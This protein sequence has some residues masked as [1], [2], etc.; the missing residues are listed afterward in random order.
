MKVLLDTDIGSDIDDAI[1]LAYLLAKPE[2]EL[3]GITT[4]SGEPQKRAML[5]SAICK[6]AG[7]EVPIFPG[8]P[9]PFLVPPRQ[10]L[11]QQAT[12]LEHWPHEKEFPEGH[13]VGFLRETIRRYPGEVTLLAIGPMTN[14][15]LLFTLDPETPQL[16]KGLYM[17]IGSF[18]T[19]IVFDGMRY[20]WNALN[21]PHA[22]AMV[23]RAQPTVHRSVGLDVTLQVQ[24]DAEEVRRR[25]QAPLLRPVL[26]MAE[27]WFK[28]RPEVT[29]HDPLAAVSLFDPAVCAYTRG[30]VDVELLSSQL[31][32]MTYFKPHEAG[33]HEVA[34]GVDKER[35][36]TEYFG[37]TG[38]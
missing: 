15:G 16:L 28:S 12:A 32:G 7:K 37:V 35:F 38:G 6:A 5:A 30:Q 33:P 4:V 24:M 22:T 19:G 29:F 18:S 23:Y 21:D 10:P 34:L 14:L 27:V 26:D 2:C 36:F 9:L 17:M 8:A 11:A 3:L 1:C 31:P 25:F 13:A 20:E